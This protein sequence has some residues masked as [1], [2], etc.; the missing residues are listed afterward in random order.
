MPYDL[1]G[2]ADEDSALRTVKAVQGWERQ[3]QTQFDDGVSIERAFIRITGAGTISPSAPAAFSTLGGEVVVASTDGAAVNGYLTMYTPV[4]LLYPAGSSA[5]ATNDIVEADLSW[6]D[7]NGKA[8]YVALAKPVTTPTTP[9]M[10]IV[11]TIT[12]AKVPASG[13]ILAYYP[14]DR[15]QAA[16]GGPWTTAEAVHVVNV[17]QSALDN[18]EAYICA[19]IG[20]TAG[21]VNV[22]ATRDNY[23]TCVGGYFE[24]NLET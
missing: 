9:D 15:L 3:Q 11:A 1:V 5:P 13:S 16:L 10:C 12:G 18:G 4:A 7:N 19:Y 8:V 20:T 24:Q 14:A 17:G 23:A 22:Y 21:G 2:F 6:F